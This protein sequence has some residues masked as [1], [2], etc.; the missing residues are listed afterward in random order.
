MDERPAVQ[1]VKRD[2]KRVIG[3]MAEIGENEQIRRYYHW[4]YDGME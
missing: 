4:R 2:R 1:Q 3:R